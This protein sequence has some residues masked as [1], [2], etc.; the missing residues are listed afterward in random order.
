MAIAAFILLSLFVGTILIST[1]DAVQEISDNKK[2]TVKRRRVEAKNHAQATASSLPMRKRKQTVVVSMLH[3]WS[4]SKHKE[5]QQLGLQIKETLHTKMQSAH[6]DGYIDTEVN[7]DWAEV[8]NIS[9]P[10]KKIYFVLSFHCATIRDNQWFQAAVNLAILIASIQVGVQASGSEGT[11]HTNEET[12]RRA[13]LGAEVVAFR[14][15]M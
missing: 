6:S 14:G 13:D 1:M 8:K 4:S 3:A 11:L 9:N 5:I 7:L 15:L 12:W 2:E 10:C